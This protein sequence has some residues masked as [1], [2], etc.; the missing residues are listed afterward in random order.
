MK[1]HERVKTLIGGLAMGK[2]EIFD[3]LEGRKVDDTAAHADYGYQCDVPKCMQEATKILEGK[4][5]KKPVCFCA[6]HWEACKVIGAALKAE[7][8]LLP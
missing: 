6:D 4:K 7:G 8:K 5:L 1:F 3:P 2:D